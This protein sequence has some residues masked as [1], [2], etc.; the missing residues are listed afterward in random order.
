MDSAAELARRIAELETKIDSLSRASQI[1]HSTVPIDGEDVSVP[2]AIGKGADAA[3]G[4]ETALTAAESALALAAE[5]KMTADGRNRIFVQD[6]E[7]LEDMVQGDLWYVTNDDGKVFEIRVFDGEEWNLYALVADSVLVPSSVGPILIADG[8]IT[9]PKVAA[10]TLNVSHLEPNIGSSIDIRINPAV[11]G[12][13]D[14]LDEQRRNFRFDEDGLAIGDPETQEEL[15]MTPG[16]VALR[17]GGRD[18]SWWEAQQ[19][20]VE[21]MVVEA[22]NIGEHR[23][24]STGPGETTIRPL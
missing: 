8:A 6:V 9:A 19:F 17:Q 18:V 4:A 15:R 10:E 13:Q 12:V 24:E 11:A 21:R 23:W 5:A 14:G 1:S 3:A 7:P 2:D 16:R 22:A 20:Y